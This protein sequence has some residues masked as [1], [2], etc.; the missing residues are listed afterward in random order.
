MIEL[1][2]HISNDL[3]CLV[4]DNGEPKPRGQPTYTTVV[5]RDKG[6]A[7]RDEIAMSLRM[8]D[9]VRPTPI[10]RE[11][12]RNPYGHLYYKQPYGK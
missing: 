5:S 4:V 3:D 2:D 6:I 12:G 7:I 8:N 1:S 9:L 10:D 11:M